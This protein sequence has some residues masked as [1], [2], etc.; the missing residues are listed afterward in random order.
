[1]VTVSPTCNGDLCFNCDLEDV[2]TTC[3]KRN[4]LDFDFYCNSARVSNST[5]RL[6]IDRELN[7]KDINWSLVQLELNNIEWHSCNKLCIKCLEYMASTYIIL[8]NIILRNVETDYTQAKCNLNNMFSNTLERFINGGSDFL[9][10]FYYE[11]GGYI[12]REDI[13]NSIKDIYKNYIV[14]YEKYILEGNLDL[15]EDEKWLEN[16]Y[17]YISRL[18]REGC[19]ISSN[20][21]QFYS[22][23]EVLNMKTYA[24]EI[25]KELGNKNE[26]TSEEALGLAIGIAEIKSNIMLKKFKFNNTKKIKIEETL[27]TY[28]KGLVSNIDNANKI[29]YEISNNTGY[30]ELDKSSVDNVYNYLIKAYQL[31]GNLLESISKGIDYGVCIQRNK[32]QHVKYSSLRRY[33]PYRDFY[34]SLSYKYNS[35]KAIGLITKGVLLEEY[36]RFYIEFIN[37]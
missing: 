33:S 4:K 18:L 29:K 16:D 22:L 28:I 34:K 9:S 7:T 19:C 26:D 32:A 8:K 6:N 13:E 20:N 24:N 3:G 11:N 10:D 27:K 37:V 35:N 36:Y 1:M 2:G 17:T 25:E 15:K 12:K 5:Y 23:E 14:Q 21:N 30:G 31:T